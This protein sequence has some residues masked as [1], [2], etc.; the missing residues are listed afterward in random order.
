MVKACADFHFS[1]FQFHRD[2]YLCIYCK[3]I[4]SLVF[5]NGQFKEKHNSGLCNVHIYI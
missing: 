5:L 1:L 3:I 4:L 2:G